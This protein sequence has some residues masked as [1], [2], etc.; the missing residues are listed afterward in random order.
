[1]MMPD[2]MSRPPTKPSQMEP[3][4]S[5]ARWQPAAPPVANP[6]APPAFARA[7]APPAFPEQ[8]QQQ[9][10]QQH[11]QQQQQQQQ[12]QGIGLSGLIQESLEGAPAMGPD[13]GQ[14]PPGGSLASS[15]GVGSQGAMMGN[16]A[17][18]L[19]MMSNLAPNQHGGFPTPAQGF[20]LAGGN[21]G[22]VN[23]QALG[24]GG[25]P[26]MSATGYPIGAAVSEPMPKK[27]RGAG[28]LIVVCLLVL[29][30]AAAVTFILLKYRAKLGI[31]LP[32]F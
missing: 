28:G 15:L 17:N 24:P 5:E 32:H 31:S 25:M 22:Q 21:P 18:Q 9:H 20:L 8:Q 2:L 6:L 19:P 10:Y 11:Y 27:K 1:M 29:V 23:V 4:Q 12:Q 16:N 13:P 7:A 3:T 30:L 14:S 26:E